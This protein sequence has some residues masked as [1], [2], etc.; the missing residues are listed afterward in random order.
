M[1]KLE[2]RVGLRLLASQ[3][4]VRVLCYPTGDPREAESRVEEL[5]GLGVSAVEFS[6]GKEVSGLRVLGKGCVGL[7][8]KAFLGR[9]EAALK[10]RRVDADRP[11]LAKEASMLRAAN[12]EGVGPRLLGFTRNFLLMEFVEG[13]PIVE[14]VEGLRDGEKELKRALRKL[15]LDC[16]KLD[17][18]GLD[19]GELSRAHKHVLVDG[20]GNP[21][22]LDFESASAGRRP[23]NLTSICQFL[24]FRSEVSGKIAST[25]GSPP[26][27]KLKGALRAYKAGATE[28]KF[29]KILEVCG[30]IE[31][32]AVV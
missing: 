12:E 11:D 31:G 22:I 20:A 1:S 7:V 32:G 2:G 15:L 9:E 3:P 4:Y 29:K 5:E 18:R 13:K 17:K 24:F 26:A 30:L 27:E 16:F 23:S 28:E 8:V 14:W 21:T 25:L 6:G 19:H 10:I